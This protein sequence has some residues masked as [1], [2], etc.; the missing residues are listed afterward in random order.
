MED[1]F[2]YRIEKT[3]PEGVKLPPNAY[4]YIRTVQNTKLGRKPNPNSTSEVLKRDEKA[5][6]PEV[7][8]IFG[9][10]SVHIIN[11]S[12]FGKIRGKFLPMARL[13]WWTRNPDDRFAPQKKPIY[14]L[15]GDT[16]NNQFKNLTL[17]K[18]DHGT[19]S[20]NS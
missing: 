3:Y 20:R 4:D 19:R 14:H 15:D 10:F 13:V 8:Q 18:T 2:Y 7:F 6:P 1:K 9:R 12:V 17:R 16:M 11:G 5:V